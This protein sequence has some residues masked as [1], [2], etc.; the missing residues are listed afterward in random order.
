MYAYLRHKFALL[1]RVYRQFTYLPS[2]Q[3]AVGFSVGI[4]LF[5]CGVVEGFA[6][7][8]ILLMLGRRKL[9][10]CVAALIIG[11]GYY[12][13][14]SGINADSQFEPVSEG[15]MGVYLVTSSPRIDD[16]NQR[17][18]LRR[19]D[20]S[21]GILAK[22]PK[23]PIVRQGDH[24]MFDVELT[25]IADTAEGVYL[26]YL[27][28]SG[29]KYAASIDNF[30]LIRSAS[31]IDQLRQSLIN[32]V[33]RSLGEPH[34]GL[35]LGM[36]V[37]ETGGFDRNLDEALRAS[38]TSHI[39]SVSGFNV[40]VI[41][42][43]LLATAGR[44]HRHRLLTLIPLLLLAYLLLVGWGN[45]PAKRAVFMSIGL[46]LPLLSGRKAGIYFGIVYAVTLMLVENPLVWRNIS[47]QLSL[48]ALVGML[49][50]A[51][52]LQSFLSRLPEFIRS[53]IATTSAA[54]IATIPI[55]ASSFG[56]MSVVALL[57]NLLIL[58][59]VP[60]AM[61]LGMFAICMSWLPLVGQFCFWLAN[62][63]LTYIIQ[64]VLFLGGLPIASTTDQMV[65]A[66]AYL[67]LLV[68]WLLADYA[69]FKRKRVN[70]KF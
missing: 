69:Q 59:A 6:T 50:L 44:V 52:T 64:T 14:T 3:I 24:V 45:L 57:A 4:I 66:V 12:W 27:Q 11:G 46:F 23:Y 30:K 28:S 42:L 22:M 34:A 60:I 49:L 48:A 53:G 40:S 18:I 47:F 13:L 21:G 20:V 36:L 31:M 63:A 35:L 39:V 41:L 32:I 26:I 70:P 68:F 1:K 17:A 51:N 67:S 55:T 8:L 16:Y 7:S 54:L 9:I 25:D 2:L 5:G 38:G 56:Q 37:G 15:S 19:D 43:M 10:I 58:P 61:Y 29:V 65:I 62:L 33:Q